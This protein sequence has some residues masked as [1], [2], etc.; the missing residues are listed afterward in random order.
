MIIFEV[1][2][3]IGFLIEMLAILIITEL[4]TGDNTVDS[5][6]CNLIKDPSS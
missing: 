4:E 1:F 3:M 6:H 5:N 2:H